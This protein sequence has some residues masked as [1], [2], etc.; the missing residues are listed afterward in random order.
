MIDEKLDE[1]LSEMQ[2]KCLQCSG[3]D[4]MNCEQKNIYRENTISQIK[5]LVVDSL[6]EEK[7]TYFTRINDCPKDCGV[8]G[9]IENCPIYSYNQKIAEMKEKFK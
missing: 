1:L 6:G 9:F 8:C 4:C 3:G 7:E 5:A 2:E